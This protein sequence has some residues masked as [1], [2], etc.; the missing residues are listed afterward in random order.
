M[1]SKM[2]VD[3]SL[4]ETAPSCP[5]TISLLFSANNTATYL[6]RERDQF[7]E[8]PN[9]YAK[10]YFKNESRTPTVVILSDSGT[11]LN[12][13]NDTA[14]G[15]ES[16]SVNERRIEQPSHWN[17]ASFLSATINPNHSAPYIVLTT[18]CH[19]DH[20]C[21]IQHLL[22]TKADLKVLTSSHDI[23]YVT[24][25]QNLQKHSLC[26]LFG[27][28]APCYDASWIEDV[29]RIS[30]NGDDGIQ[31][32][33]SSLVVIHTPGHTP[34][35]LSWYDYDSCTLCVGDMFYE[36]ES[37]ETRSGSR[38]RWSREP[39]QPVV[40][41]Q[42][43]SIIEWNASMHRLLDFVRAE[44]R[45]LGTEKDAPMNTGYRQDG[46]G[47]ALS[48]TE[49]RLADGDWSMVQNIPARRRV[50]LCAAH[51]TIG[52]DA[53]FAILDML[54]F[55]LRIQLDQVPKKQIHDSYHGNNVWLW[56]DCLQSESNDG[57]KGE[58]QHSCQ[59]SVRAPWTIIHKSSHQSTYQKSSQAQISINESPNTDF[60]SML[61]QITSPSLNAGKKPYLKSNALSS[62]SHNSVMA[63]R[64]ASSTRSSARKG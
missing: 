37:D 55:M 48:Y 15:L 9:I 21:G 42:D 40:F 14:Y 63:D 32:Q 61:R 11:G 53:E 47:T 43:S 46:Q 6:I 64:P 57:M 28:K 51:V 22:E 45:R 5:Y 44:N 62:V 10:V 19:Y 33:E 24:P 30:F 38:G 31:R 54:A 27:L 12:I 39:P 8:F 34:D 2:D 4:R 35:S 23:T 41:T 36:K 49:I 60:R 17:I 26:E 29:Q 1:L 3:Q 7:G 59:Y 58:A 20:I 13:V 52:T 50:V 16:Q 18:H 25:W 56:D